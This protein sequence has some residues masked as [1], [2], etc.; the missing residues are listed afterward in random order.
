MSW[1]WRLSNWKRL[2][3]SGVPQLKDDSTSQLPR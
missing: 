2:L 3:N 1:E